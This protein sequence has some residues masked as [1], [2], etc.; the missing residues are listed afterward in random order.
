MN[1]FYMNKEILITGGTGTLGKEITKQ[2][3]K[4]HPEIRGIRIFSRD[5]EKHRLLKKELGE[6][7]KVGFLIGNIKD[8]ERLSRA[9]NRVDIVFHTA[10]MKQIDMCEENPI[11]AVRIN[12]DGSANVIDCA[13]DNV[14]QNVMLIS[15]DKACYPINIYGV[16]KAAAEKL[17]LHSSVYAPRY[18]NFSICRYGNV[19]SSRGSVI[20]IFQEQYKKNKVLAATN[21]EMTRFWIELKKVAEFV[22][23]RMADMKGGE[24][25]VPE[26]RSLSMENLIKAIFPKDDFKIKVIGIR[27]GEKMHECL[28]TEEESYFRDAIDGNYTNGTVINKETDISKLKFAL[29]SLNALR[30]DRKK[31]RKVINEITE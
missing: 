31:L 27:Q 13:I 28:I 8:K 3:L 5:E 10:A 15:T 18:T 23:K 17:F 6:T 16:T 30:W 2:L 26:M 11:E 29:T 9:M 19:I 21:L 22:I 20:P 25:F 24:I 7:N 14:V 1:S 12:V 4:N